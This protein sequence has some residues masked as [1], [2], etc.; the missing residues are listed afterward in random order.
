M[1]EE[2]HAGALLNA[3]RESHASSPRARNVLLYIKAL[4]ARGL[5]A[6]AERKSTT[7]VRAEYSTVS[8]L[9]TQ[10]GSGR[11]FRRD[12]TLRRVLRMIKFNFINYPSSWRRTSLAKSRGFNGP[13]LLTEDETWCTWKLFWWSVSCLKWIVISIRV[14]QSLILIK[15][16]TKLPLNKNYSCALRHIYFNEFYSLLY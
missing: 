15:K 7:A 16:N 11:T 5:L 9:F 2:R 12:Q 13:T 14:H 10:V 1:C 3:V 8:L 6:Q 4:S